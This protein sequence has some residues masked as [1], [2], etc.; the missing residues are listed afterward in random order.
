MEKFNDGLNIDYSKCVNENGEYIIPVE[1][2]MYSTVKVKNAENLQQ[3]LDYLQNHI[4]DIPL[5]KGEYIDSSYKIDNRGESMIDAQ[6]Y[7]HFGEVEMS[8]SSGVKAVGIH[9]DVDFE[10]IA[11][12]MSD[13]TYER[14]AE[15]LGISADKY[16]AMTE[17]EQEEYLY[18]CVHHN[19]QINYSLVA[20]IMGLPEEI[21]I[22]EEEC[23]YDDEG[24]LD[25]D[26]IVDWLSD[27]YEFVVEG[28]DIE[29]EKQN[30]VYKDEME[31]R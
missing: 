6:S 18:Q 19:G 21:E 5:G 1:W 17:E 26:H 25:N 30:T 27:E 23:L 4:D 12:T 31:D 2:S 20:E 3:A 8:A 13:M 28:L 24:V 29:D 14:G 10:D 15:I 22:P 9:W 7:K 11:D 16:R